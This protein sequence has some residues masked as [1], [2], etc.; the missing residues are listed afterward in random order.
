MQRQIRLWLSTVFLIDFEPNH[1]S[2]WL[3]IG[4]LVI[5]VYITAAVI[6]SII[7]TAAVKL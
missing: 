7:I 2:G 3:Q 6:N 4:Y 5:A 1:N